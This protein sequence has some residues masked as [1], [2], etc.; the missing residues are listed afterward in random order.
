MKKIKILS[1]RAFSSRVFCFFTFVFFRSSHPYRYEIFFQKKQKGTGGQ[2]SV[3]T[4]STNYVAEGRNSFWREFSNFQRCVNLT[5]AQC[6]SFYPI[7]CF[8]CFPLQ[9]QTG[10]TAYP[11]QRTVVRCQSTLS[12]LRV[13]LCCNLAD[14][15]CMYRSDKLAFSSFLFFVRSI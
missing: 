9:Q 2:G 6:V 5:F 13:E 15:V 10:H 3:Y 4:R 8:R 1:F 11:R 14:N 12:L 7:F